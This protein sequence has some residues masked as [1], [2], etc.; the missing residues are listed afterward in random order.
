[1]S[2]L[3]DCYREASDDRDTLE[4]RCKDL[5]SDLR[6]LMEDYIVTF[7]QIIKMNSRGKT[8]ELDVTCTEAIESLREE[9]RRIR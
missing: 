8:R 6:M 3:S 4:E 2:Y 1:M 7:E 5:K 9:L